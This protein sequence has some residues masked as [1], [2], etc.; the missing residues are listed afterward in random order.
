MQTKPC[1]CCGTGY[2]EDLLESHH[3]VPRHLNGSDDPINRIDI[4]PICHTA[5]H[6]VARLLKTDTTKV[7]SWLELNYPCNPKARQLILE[8]ARVILLE[9]EQAPVKDYVNFPMR[10]SHE[11]HRK[12]KELTRESHKDRK[13]NMHD[14]VVELIEAEWRRRRTP[15]VEKL[16]RF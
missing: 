4:C 11:V 15:L 1:G 12:L 7:A 3:K 10:L 9:A 6:T 13:G 14:L 16:R 8:L 2:S 5:V